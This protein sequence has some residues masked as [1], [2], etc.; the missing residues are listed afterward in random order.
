MVNNSTNI[1]KKL[2]SRITKMTMTYVVG[3][4]SPLLGQEQ[5]CGGVKPVPS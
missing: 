2:N 4:P 5:K 3:N 1:K